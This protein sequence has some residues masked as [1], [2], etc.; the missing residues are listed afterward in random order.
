REAGWPWW[1][2]AGLA[3]AVSVLGCFAATLPRRPAPLIHPS[4][5]RD[6]TAR[7]GVLLVFVFNAGVPSFTYLLFVHLQTALGY[8]VVAAALM[9]AP[10]A[11]AAV[12]GSRVAPA[13]SHRYG[14]AV[15]TVA[16]LML[17]GMV[18]GLALLVQTGVGHWAAIPVLAV[19][20]VAFG[21]FTAS[22]FALVLAKVD[23]AAAGSVS[24]LLPTAQQLGGSI[25]V[26]AAGLAY[27]TSP[28]GAFWHAMIYEAAVFVVAALVSLRLRGRLLVE[29]EPV[30]QDAGRAGCRSRRMPSGEDAVRGG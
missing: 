5:W 4:V 1:T 23:G 17:A 19:G 9:S 10:F 18:L 12:L 24:G 15:L 14:S 26:A 29:A 3:V 2:W 28:G 20:G 22:V 7:W 30:A 13:L 11:A 8:A 27:F 6:R 16:S 25:G 21:S